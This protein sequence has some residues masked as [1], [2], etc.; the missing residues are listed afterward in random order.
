VGPTKR[1]LL[2][3]REV[4]LVFTSTVSSPDLG[5]GHIPTKWVPSLVDP[6]VN[7]MNVLPPIKMSRIHGL[8][9]P[10]Y[11][12]SL[13][14][15]SSVQ[16]KIYFSYLCSLR[17]VFIVDFRKGIFAG[18]PHLNTIVQM[19]YSNFLGTFMAVP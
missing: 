6:N 1:S 17:S 12:S 10:R 3:R 4:I 9:L 16:R 5:P 13:W 11:H 19:F 2:M 18:S 14:Q 8:L 15:G 7:F